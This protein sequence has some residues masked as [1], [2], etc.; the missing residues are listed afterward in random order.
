MYA[1]P[2]LAESTACSAQANMFLIADLLTM[3]E[4]EHAT[5]MM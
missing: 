2:M 3:A 4:I 1:A 5:R